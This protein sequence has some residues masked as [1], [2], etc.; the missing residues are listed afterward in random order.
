MTRRAR[1]KI[2]SAPAT[3]TAVIDF[4]LGIF[5]RISAVF[6]CQALTQ[7]GWQFLPL[8]CE[9]IERVLGYQRP[10][11][12]GIPTRGP[13]STLVPTAKPLK[14][15][16]IKS[17]SQYRGSRRCS[18]ASGRSWMRSA[19]RTKLPPTS[20]RRRRPRAWASPCATPR[21]WPVHGPTCPSMN[22]S[23]DPYWENDVA[24]RNGA[25]VRRTTRNCHSPLA[26]S[27]D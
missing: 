15:P 21:S 5:A 23:I 17:L 26:S 24:R 27:N 1:A 11:R 19:S 16:L 2:L 12:H 18:I 9:A 3:R 13:S 4:W 7:E 22:R 20:V 14:L 6:R 8:P 10:I 25:D